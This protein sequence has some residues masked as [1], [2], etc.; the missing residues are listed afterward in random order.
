MAKLGFVTIGSTGPGV[1]P[2]LYFLDGTSLS[3]D[4]IRTIS[5]TYDPAK[6]CKGHLDLMAAVTLKIGGTKQG[7]VDSTCTYP[8]YW[9]AGVF[10]GPVVNHGGSFDLEIQ[11]VKRIDF[12]S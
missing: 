5:L 3:F 7:L 6:A 1:S 2:I 10:T 8:D 9:D 11:K 12:L 4:D